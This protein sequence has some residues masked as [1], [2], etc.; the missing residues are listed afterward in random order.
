MPIYNQNYTKNEIQRIINRIK[1]SVKQN[2]YM[3]SLNEHRQENKE[4]IEL[5]QLHSLKQKKILLHLKIED[6]CYSL[7]NHHPTYHH[8]TL[9]VFAPN[10]VLWNIQGYPETIN[11]YIKINIVP[12]MKK[13]QV[14]IISF[15]PNHQQAHY[16]FKREDVSNEKLCLL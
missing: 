14:I 9:Y 10:L 8:E 1:N 6:F 16:L 5:Y 11:V 15:H 2:H 3:I 7:E 12:K 4:F 13:K